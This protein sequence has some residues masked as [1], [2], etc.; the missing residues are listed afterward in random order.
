MLKRTGVYDFT[1]VQ[2]LF[3]ALGNIAY[4]LIKIHSE[5]RAAFESILLNY[6]M[7]ALNSKSD[8]LNFCLQ[9][10]AI[11]LQLE[12]STNPQY[13]AI[14]TSLLMP[15]NWKE[16]NQ[17]LMSSYIQFLISF[18]AKHKSKLIE[19][20]G[21]VEIILSKIIEIDHVELF[22]RFMEAIMINTTLQ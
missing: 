2:F 5:H 17:S 10:L 16:E 11:F 6:F 19:D 3:E 20:K 12:S 15:E 4:Y 8:L 9:I 18:I 7:E 14:Y 13:V 21:A 22:Y 1:S